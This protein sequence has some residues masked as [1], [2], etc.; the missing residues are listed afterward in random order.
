MT[1]SNSD[2]AALHV[3]GLL[4]FISDRRAPDRDRRRDPQVPAVRDRPADQPHDLV[5]DHHRPAGRRCSSGSSSSR[6]MCCR[7]PRRSRVAASTLA[8]AALFNP[9]RRRVQ[10][11]RRPALQPRP[12]RRRSGRR[13]VHPAATGSSR[14]RDRP[15]RAR[16][17]SHRSS[18]TRAHL[19]LD[20]TSHLR[21]TATQP[22]LAQHSGLTRRHGGLVGFGSPKSPERVGQDSRMSP[23]FVAG[24]VNGRA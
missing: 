10:H 17:R 4:G 8:A 22:R 1:I 16:R 11:R 2:V 3:V 23:E 24:S 15:P 5:P 20:Q 7:S 18:A 21:K 19:P 12:L 6:P 14:P 9:L 13:S